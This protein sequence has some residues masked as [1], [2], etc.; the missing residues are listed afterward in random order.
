[1]CPASDGGRR[2]A[3]ELAHLM[4]S[5]A[6]WSARDFRRS[7]SFNVADAGGSLN[8]DQ[9]QAGFSHEG[10]DSTRDTPSPPHRQNRTTYNENLS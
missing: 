6:A 5:G 8:R 1:M 2:Y 3:E 10:K 4:N 7:P 9:H